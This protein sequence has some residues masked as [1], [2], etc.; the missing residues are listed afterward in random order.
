VLGAV[1]YAQTL[2][3]DPNPDFYLAKPHL[4]ALRNAALHPTSI[5]L[6]AVPKTRFSGS[7]S[8]C[9]GCPRSHG[10]GR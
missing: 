6:P 9:A 2:G 3:F 8:D 10:R 4:G 7:C 5:D 1:E